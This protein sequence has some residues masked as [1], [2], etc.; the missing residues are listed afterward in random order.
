LEWLVPAR[1]IVVCDG[2]EKKLHAETMGFLFRLVG[3]QA[4]ITFPFWE[5]AMGTGFWRTGDA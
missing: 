5:G 2:I 3:S 4:D 1:D